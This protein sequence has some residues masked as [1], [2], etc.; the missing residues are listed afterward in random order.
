MVDIRI[1]AN[2]PSDVHAPH[3]DPIY[4]H[5]HDI[6]V[7][8]MGWEALRRPDGREIDRFDDEH[9]VHIVAERDGRVVGYSR[10]LQTV[11][12][13]LL[14]TV[15]PEILQGAAPPRDP[16]I[17]E[18]TRFSSDPADSDGSQMFGPIAR[19]I[20]LAVVEWCVANELKGLSVQ[21]H[22]FYLPRM[23]ELKWNAMPLALETDYEGEALVAMMT[24]PDAHTLATMRGFFGI[25]EP[26]LFA[27]L[28]GASDALRE[29]S[30]RFA[31]P[32]TS[33]RRD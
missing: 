29:P 26:V 16:A 19:R 27:D 23:L 33:A 13:H 11:R 5:R 31:G 24:R 14:D 32:D 2:T 10:M 15:Y 22:P 9:A 18:W 12:P 30:V 4:A 1:I 25:R 17:W 8:R 21:L 6:F 7:E 28:P 20:L 3:M